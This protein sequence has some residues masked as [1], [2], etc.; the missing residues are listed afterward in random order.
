MH[1]GYFDDEAREYVITEPRTPVKWINYVGTLAFGGFVD[2]TGGA[3]ICKG[4]PALNRITRYLAWLPASAFKATSLYLRL[5]GEDGYRLISP[6]FVPGL[7]PLDRFE[8]HVGLGYTRLLSEVH[9]LR[10]EATFFVP[11][12]DAPGGDSEAAGPLILD[13][14]V[15]NLSGQPLDVDAIPVVEYSHFDALRQLVNADWVPQTM[16]S[17]VHDEEGGYKTLLQYAFMRRDTAVNYFTSNRPASSFE[18]DRARFLGGNEYGTWAQP[19]SLQAPELGNYEARRGDNVAALLHHLGTVPPGATAR[20][21]VQLGQAPGLDAALPSIHTYRD[22]GQVDAAFARLRHFWDGYL[23]RLQVETPDANM[24]RMLNVHNP[25]QCY[26][27]FNWS[28]Y[29]S[30]YQLGYGARG[31]GFRDSSQDAM[32]IMAHAPAEARRLLEKLLQVQRPDGSAMHQFNPLTMVAN[33]G[34]AREYEEA[35]QYYGD[36]HLWIVLAVG[37][38]LKE[39]GDLAFLETVLPFYQAEMIE[40]ARHRGQPADE[41][42]ARYREMQARVDEHGWDGAWYVRYF[43][44][45]GRP[46]GSRHNSHG[47]IYANG[48][49]WPVLSGFAPAGRAELALE[50]VHERLNTAFGLKLSAPGY[51]GYDPAVGGISTYPPGAKENG[52]IFVHANPWVIMAEALLGHGDRAFGYYD[53]INPAAHNDD[54][55]RFQC[56]PYAYPQNILAD[57]HPQFG[58]ARNSWLTGAASWSYQAATQYLLGI[59]PTYDGLRIDPCI[60]ARWPGFRVTRHFRGALYHIEVH[61]PHGLC[62]GACE[63]TIDGQQLEIEGHTLPLLP[64]NHTYHVHATLRPDPNIQYP[65]PNI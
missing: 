35:P 43:D 60:P 56:E 65:I 14:E 29:L 13:V 42:R 24:D 23:A 31:M 61:N 17:R 63:I 6:F 26:V 9:G 36:D 38:Y 46:L 28:R 54:A 19:L 44:A 53:Q 62:K 50:A 16:Q 3:L 20:L 64:P 32:G 18:T 4:D 37:A 57:E 7:E 21:V 40:L 27:T 51:D 10:T 34:D 1:Y 47:Q 11:P 25:R 49:S 58:L 8:C 41:Y 30:L 39:T 33:A 48:Q 45:E 2:H 15:T 52:G 59:R 12:G 55:D 22:E 5:P